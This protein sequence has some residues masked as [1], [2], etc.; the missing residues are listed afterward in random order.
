MESTKLMTHR[1]IDLELYCMLHD[2]S[3]TRCSSTLD[4]GPH[5]D[6]EHELGDD[7]CEQ[8]GQCSISWKIGDAASSVLETWQFLRAEKQANQ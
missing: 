3:T 4:D 7:R 1:I 5:S 6:V 2:A 8:F